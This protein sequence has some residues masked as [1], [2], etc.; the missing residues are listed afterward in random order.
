MDIQLLCSTINGWGIRK[1]RH[2]EISLKNLIFL[3]SA[4]LLIGT[5]DDLNLVWTGFSWSIVGCFFPKVTHCVFLVISNMPKKEYSPL[6]QDGVTVSDQSYTSGKG[7]V[8]HFH[9]IK[10]D[11]GISGHQEMK[12]EVSFHVVPENVTKPSSS[13][14]RT[15]AIQIKE[16]EF[17]AANGLLQPEKTINFFESFALISNN[18]SGPAMMGLPH[19]FHVAGVVPVV[20]AIVLVF[21]ASSLVGRHP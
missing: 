15:L 5:T 3:K 19:L 8:H 6:L 13:S 9:V 17:A 14:T 11:H 10:H 16:N 20:V 21:F 12:R 7:G 4:L 2:S 18:I 1:K